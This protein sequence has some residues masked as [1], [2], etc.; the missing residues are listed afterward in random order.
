MPRRPR[1]IGLVATWVAICGVFSLAPSVKAFYG[2]RAL[3]PAGPTAP[4]VIHLLLIVATIVL[5]RAV[6]KMRLAAIWIS[7]GLLALWVVSLIIKAP[8]VISAS[9]HPVRA[10][11]FIGA[12]GFP[13]LLAIWYLSR[14][15]FREASVQYRKDSDAEA[16]R[17]DAETLES[18]RGRIALSSDDELRRIVDGGTGD[19]KPEVV[20]LAAELLA[21]RNAVEKDD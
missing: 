6:L 2:P 13:N 18:V 16:V 5:V 1:G 10:A 8:F 3:D 19:F 15:S 7:V 4:K 9:P 11:I 20:D 14:R 21:L 12:L 17:R